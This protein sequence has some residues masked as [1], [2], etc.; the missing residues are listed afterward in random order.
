MSSETSSSGPE[1]LA[2]PPAR[3]AESRP[4][5]PAASLRYAPAQARGN[6]MATAALIV[7]ILA[8]IA[9]PVGLALGC[10]ALVLS[11][12]AL[13][14]A[15]HLSG[16]R[17]GRSAAIAGLCLG[18]VGGVVGIGFVV[19][20]ASRPRITSKLD[21][22][23]WNLRG[24]GQG[25][26]VYANDNSD[27]YPI[28]LF[29]PAP[30]DGSNATEVSFVGQLGVNRRSCLVPKPREHSLGKIPDSSYLDPNTP[31]VTA[32]QNAIHPSRSLFMLVVDGTCTAKQFICPVSQ[33]TEDD[34]GR[35]H[36]YEIASQPAL[37][38]FD[39][40]GY[41]HLSYGYQLPFGRFGRLSEDLDA[42]MPLVADKGP[43]YTAGTPRS[44]DSIP[45]QPTA[46]PGSPVTISGATT[47]ADVQRLS[48]GQWRPY[49]SRNHR[50]EG[51]NVL[52]VDG[53]VVFERTPIVGIGQYNIYPL[54][55]PG[56]TALDVM[57]GLV[58][59]D[60]QGPRT[61]TDSVIVP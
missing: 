9:F 4:E 56:G 7:G 15:R 33:D 39:F 3:E 31:N 20:L 2:A 29:H 36:P 25:M 32:V 24:I 8:V 13:G 54:Q 27:S 5:L 59:A 60:K 21:V 47:A 14:R 22:C 43:F 42:R 23:A 34:L 53:S 6:G 30:D 50:Q 44:D 28:V 10:V 17:T 1:S 12:I 58:P 57:L 18:L 26:E 55:G 11:T 38:R 37:N 41:S 51:Q 52:R 49:N 19:P 16:P 35:A 48:P 40:L 61:N 45:D 46:P